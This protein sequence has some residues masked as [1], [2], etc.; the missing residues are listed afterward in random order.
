MTRNSFFSSF[1][2]E[3]KANRLKAADQANT[4]HPERST[5]RRTSGKQ[6][7]RVTDGSSYPLLSSPF[8][9]YREKWGKETEDDF[10]LEDCMQT[11]KGNEMN[12]LTAREHPVRRRKKDISVFQTMMQL[13]ASRHLTWS[14][15]R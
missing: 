2:Q 5:G 13:H 9:C 3:K 10:M 4:H 7:E 11:C 14:R 12:S 8:A 6:M 1:S 15:S